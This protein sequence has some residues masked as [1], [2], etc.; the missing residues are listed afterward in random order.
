MNWT[1][2]VGQL[3]Q[4][5]NAARKFGSAPS[6]MHVAVRISP[7]QVI[8]L[9]LTIE[10]YSEAHRRARGNTEDLPAVKMPNRPGIWLL[11]AW[12]SGLMLGAGIAWMIKG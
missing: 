5:K 7:W 6:Y 10:E 2:T 4:V 11:V 3:T 9:L 12:L 1:T 8:H